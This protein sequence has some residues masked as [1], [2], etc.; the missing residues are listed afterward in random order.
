MIRHRIAFATFGNRID[1]AWLFAAQLALN[2]REDLI[3]YGVI[4]KRAICLMIRP[5]LLAPSTSKA[6]HFGMSVDWVVCS[7]S[8]I[9]FAPSLW[10]VFLR[11]CF[12][13]AA[14]KIET[15]GRSF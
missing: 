10:L 12:P 9:F 8:C 4:S 11:R 13:L 15:T 7:C 2:E 3:S 14:K 1:W 6:D 5:G